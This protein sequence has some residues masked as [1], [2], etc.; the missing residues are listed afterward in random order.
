MPAHGSLQIFVPVLAR[1]RRPVLRSAAQRPVF[2]RKPPGSIA[3]RPIGVQ[4]EYDPPDVWII[5]QVCFQL[6]VMQAAERD[7]V[8]AAVERDPAHQVDG[9]L[10][11]MDGIQRRAAGQTER[12][13]LVAAGHVALERGTACPA[14]GGE[15][16]LPGSVAPYEHAVVVLRVLVEQARLDEAV[17]DAGGD[18]SPAQV[19]DY[20]PVV[21]MR[22]RK[23]ESPPIR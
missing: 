23:G 10:E 19:G 1:R 4:T 2:R 9:R 3:P 12:D 5:T 7:G 13:P 22:R 17:Y 15:Y 21:A 8:A 14:L 11:H 20:A 18:A 16:R 6:S